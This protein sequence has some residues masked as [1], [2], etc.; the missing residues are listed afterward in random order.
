MWSEEGRSSLLPYIGKLPYLKAQFAC[1]PV[2]CS[3]DLLWRA[4]GTAR[5][6]LPELFS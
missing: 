6:F 2:S 1:F 5:N 4:E 3:C